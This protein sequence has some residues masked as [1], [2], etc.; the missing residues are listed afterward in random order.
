LVCKIA[1]RRHLPGANHLR[2]VSCEGYRPAPLF[3]IQANHGYP[4]TNTLNSPHT[5]TPT[6]LSCEENAN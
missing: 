4:E 1:N 3:D 5:L 2:T 6:Y